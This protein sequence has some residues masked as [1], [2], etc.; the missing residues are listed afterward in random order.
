M[1]SRLSWRRRVCEQEHGPTVFPDAAQ[2]QNGW[3][4]R[5][6]YQPGRSGR[7]ILDFRGPARGRWSGRQMWSDD[8]RVM[9]VPEY[10]AVRTRHSRTGHR[11]DKHQSPGLVAAEVKTAGQSGASDRATV[12]PVRL[13]CWS[14]PCREDAGQGDAEV[15]GEVGLDVA[16]RLAAPRI[17][18]H[19][20]VHDGAGVGLSGVDMAG[21]AGQRAAP[22]LV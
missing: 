6:S 19:V 2:R 4:N 7:T 16:V 12:A 3:R 22:G 11:S 13:G 10:P 8:R 1:I 5:G 9:N 21:G 15:H 20:R 18:E 14:V 17:A